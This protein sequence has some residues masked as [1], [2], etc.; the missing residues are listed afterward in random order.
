MSQKKIRIKAPKPVK[1]LT[2]LRK[3]IRK[4]VNTVETAEKEVEKESEKLDE[5]QDIT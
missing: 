1:D 5:F 4:L 3:K 2:E